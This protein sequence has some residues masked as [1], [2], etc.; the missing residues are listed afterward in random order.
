[1]E[2]GRFYSWEIISEDVAV[3]ECD[4]SFFDYNGSGLPKE[5]RPFFNSEALREG[6]HKDI[7]LRFQGVAYNAHIIRESPSVGHGRTRIFWESRL[8]NI[9]SDFYKISQ[10]YPTV[11]FQRVESNIFEVV[12]FNL[13]KIEEE[14]ID[15]RESDEI[16]A[17]KEGKKHY[18][19]TARYERKPENRTAA[20]KIH[21]LK[22]MACGFDF[23][24]F[25]GALGKD[26]IEVH[27]VKPLA[28]TDEEIEV[29][30]QTDLICLCS[31]CHSM[32]HRNKTHTL[33]LEE[34]KSIIRDK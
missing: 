10:S 30:P 16:V 19:F 15:P 24:E 33:S 9:F 22:C 12:F 23:E 5:V 1:M 31:N 29:N 8:G 21:G 13:K 14:K 2:T 25:Y 28:Y 4:K 20:I 3:K 18:I 32:I 11:R 34:L 7:V 6:E 17:E 27:H 26:F